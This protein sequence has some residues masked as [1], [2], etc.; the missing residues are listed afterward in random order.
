[1]HIARRMTLLALIAISA[2]PGFGVG[3]L[4]LVE[5]HSYH[6]PDDTIPDPTKAE[7]IERAHRK[8]RQSLGDAEQFQQV[9]AWEDWVQCYSLDSSPFCW[10]GD[11]ISKASF[12]RR[13]NI[14]EPWH[15][16]ISGND[17]WFAEM[18]NVA[19]ME[20][21]RECARNSVLKKA[22]FF[23]GGTVVLP[24][25]NFHEEEDLF[26]RYTYTATSNAKKFS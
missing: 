5:G 21:R 16:T 1:M 3:N 9:S 2:N 4:V 24:A 19:E 6:A 25:L 22:R 20:R 18:T 7:L 14:D 10:K 13:E 26:R 12:V 17:R 23:C 8:G 15:I 11:G